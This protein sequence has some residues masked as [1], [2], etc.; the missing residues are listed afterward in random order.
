MPNSKLCTSPSAP[1]LHLCLALAVVIRN[2]STS[3]VC[4]MKCHRFWDCQKTLPLLSLASKNLG[5]V[6]TNSI[7]FN[8]FAASMK[9][10]NFSRPFDMTTHLSTIA[11]LFSFATMKA[12][13]SISQVCITFYYIGL[14]I[15]AS[16]TMSSLKFSRRHVPSS[17]KDNGRLISLVQYC[18]SKIQF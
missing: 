15:A 18:E 10:Q 1:V 13:I 5:I 17:F 12:S 8:V 11:L 16:Q 14:S 6:H 4:L 7:W 2:T 3:L 9:S